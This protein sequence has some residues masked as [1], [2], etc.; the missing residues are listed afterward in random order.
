MVRRE[1]LVFIYLIIL[2]SDVTAF[3][4]Y[5]R[6]YRSQEIYQPDNGK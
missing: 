3:A 2:F 6:H 1:I 4:F 5:Y